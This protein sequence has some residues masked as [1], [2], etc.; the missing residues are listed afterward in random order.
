L[1]T[2][3]SRGDEKAPTRQ[4]HP[5]GKAETAEYEKT[6]VPITRES[7]GY[8]DTGTKAHPGFQI[9]MKRHILENILRNRRE[10]H[11]NTEL[12]T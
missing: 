2:G 9:T 7:S 3:G 1:Q 6:G 12:I 10:T 11:Y 5:A 8:R 4:S